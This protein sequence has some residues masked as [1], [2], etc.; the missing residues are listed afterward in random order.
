MAVTASICLPHLTSITMAIT[1]ALLLVCVVLRMFD[2]PV[3]DAWAM[4]I[5]LFIHA[6]AFDIS[7][8]MVECHFRL[9]RLVCS[10]VYRFLYL[11]LSFSIMCCFWYVF[12][13]LFVPCGG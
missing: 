2:R 13:H 7:L 5:L 8:C 3:R 9:Y 4:R 12:T 11:H 10:F 6:L 1:V